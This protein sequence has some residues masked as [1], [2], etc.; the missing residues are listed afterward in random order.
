MI[1]HEQVPPYTF[2]HTHVCMYVYVYVCVCVCVLSLLLGDCWKGPELVVDT[3]DVG[4]PIWLIW[5][6]RASTEL[7]SSVKQHID[8]LLPPLISVT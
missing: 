3:W 4:E 6:R 2:M 8:S 1:S 7:Q 5:A